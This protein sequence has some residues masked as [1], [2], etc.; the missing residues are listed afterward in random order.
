MTDKAKSFVY[1]TSLVIA[2]VTY[3]TIDRTENIE[4]IQVAENAVENTSSVEA[5]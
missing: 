3:S 5:L 1:F 4:T 2:F